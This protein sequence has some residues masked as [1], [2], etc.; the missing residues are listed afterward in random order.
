M[1]ISG[2]GESGIRDVLPHSGHPRESGEP[3]FFVREPDG[4][5]LDTG[6]ST[7]VPAFAG[8][9]GGGAGRVDMKGVNS[10]GWTI[11]PKG[12]LGGEISR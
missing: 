11:A 1:R 4:A 10:L 5:L 9:T 12:R 6:E 3:G 2:R 8:M 7:W